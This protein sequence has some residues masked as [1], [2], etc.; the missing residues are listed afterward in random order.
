MKVVTSTL[1]AI[2]AIATEIECAYRRVCV[3]RQ[4][5]MMIASGYDVIQCVPF[6]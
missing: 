1:H 2:I 5:Q 4:I 3:A 6:N